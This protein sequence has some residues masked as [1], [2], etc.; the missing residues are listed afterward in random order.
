VAQSEKKFESQKEEMEF[1]EELGFKVNQE[2]ILTKN[3]KEVW[4]HYQKLIKK[5]DKFDY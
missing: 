2:R 1:L 3:L 5:K 4:A